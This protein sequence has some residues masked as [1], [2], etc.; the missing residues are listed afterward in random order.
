LA[1]GLTGRIFAPRGGAFCDR[2]GEE[3][4]VVG[5]RFKAPFAGSKREKVNPNLVGVGGS[6]PTQKERKS[7]CRPYIRKKLLYLKNNELKGNKGTKKGR[8]RRA[9]GGGLLHNSGR[10]TIFFRKVC[11]GRK[12][13]GPVRVEP[14]KKE[15]K[16][17]E[18]SGSTVWIAD[19]TGV[20]AFGEAEDI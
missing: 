20:Q 14:K 1:T 4:L 12:G 7:V 10:E 5:D 8:E 16:F 11:R 18:G 9:P 19:N 13:G 3:T 15:R 17:K 2:D 6:I